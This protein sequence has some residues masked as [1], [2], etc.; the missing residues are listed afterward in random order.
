MPLVST[1]PEV[2]VMSSDTGDTVVDELTSQDVLEVLE[3]D[4]CQI[5]GEDQ[6]IATRTDSEDDPLVE[7]PLRE[8]GPGPPV[9][10]DVHREDESDTASVVHNRFH[11]NRLI[12]NFARDRE[13]DS[14]G[15]AEMELQT[16]NDTVEETQDVLFVPIWRRCS[17]SVLV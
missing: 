13:G 9:E 7:E 3:Q 15:A 2:F 11:R 16:C 4:L 12:L 14:S 1:G 8:N 6:P 5:E 10:G 17:K